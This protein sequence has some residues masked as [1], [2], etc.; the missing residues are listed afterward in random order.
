MINKE[1][2]R[3]MLDELLMSVDES[4]LCDSIRPKNIEPVMV[5]QDIEKLKSYYPEEEE[6]KK[7]KR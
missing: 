6:I 7:T 1:M 5:Y 4:S 2:N 3:F